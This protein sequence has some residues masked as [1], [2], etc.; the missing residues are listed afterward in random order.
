MWL[1]ATEARR[2]RLCTLVCICE[3]AALSSPVA[4]RKI[5][6]FGTDSESGGAS[7]SEALRGDAVAQA[8]GRH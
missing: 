1:R 6:F 4:G 7:N 2:I 3:I 5:A 8:D